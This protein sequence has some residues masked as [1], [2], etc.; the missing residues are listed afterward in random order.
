MT[1]EYIKKHLEFDMLMDVIKCSSSSLFGIT[2]SSF[3]KLFRNFRIKDSKF[4]EIKENFIKT[5]EYNNIF[6]K[7]C[8]EETLTAKVYIFY[9]KIS[10]LKKFVKVYNTVFNTKLDEITFKNSMYRSVEDIKESKSNKGYFYMI[11]IPECNMI[12]L[13]NYCSGYINPSEINTIPDYV[14]NHQI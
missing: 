1:N 4:K 12:I 2:Y 3:G 6:V 13:K 9:D 14:M 11:L 5:E 7:S 8:Y 10:N